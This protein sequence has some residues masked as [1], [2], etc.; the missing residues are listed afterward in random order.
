MVTRMIRSGQLNPTPPAADFMRTAAPKQGQLHGEP[1][2]RLLA[3]HRGRQDLH[4][5]AVLKGDSP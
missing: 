3:V 4:G 2:P 5:R 1:V